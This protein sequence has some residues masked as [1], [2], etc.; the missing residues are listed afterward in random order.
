MMFL[1][2]LLYAIFAKTS[3][4]LTVLWQNAVFEPIILCYFSLNTKTIKRM[5][6]PNIKFILEEFYACKGKAITSER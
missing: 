2:R 4:V 6:V 1:R 3:R 5:L